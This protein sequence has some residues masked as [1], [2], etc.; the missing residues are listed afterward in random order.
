M[1]AVH[2]DEERMPGPHQERPPVGGRDRI[3]GV[4]ALD[5]HHARAHAA[6]DVDGVDGADPVAIALD[7][8]PPAAGAAVAAARQGEERHDG[9][10][11][12]NAAQ[13]RSVPLSELREHGREG[14]E[15]DP[16]RACP[17]RVRVVEAVRLELSVKGS[18]TGRADGRPLPVGEPQQVDV[19]PEHVDGDPALDVLE[20]QGWEAAAAR[21]VAGRVAAR[22]RSWERVGG[23]EASK[24][25][26]R[27]FP[28]DATS[29]A[30]VW[31]SVSS[32]AARSSPAANGIVALVVPAVFATATEPSGWSR[33]TEPPATDSS[34]SVPKPARRTAQRRSDPS[35][36]LGHASPVDA[37]RKTALRSGCGRAT[38]AHAGHTFHQSKA[39]SE[40]SPATR[41]M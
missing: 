28:P 21:V 19:A 23:R 31:P 30:S 20:A 37:T 33:A 15:R 10:E 25:R 11:D 3:V 26:S 38:P 40:P 32:L 41:P 34:L 17:A 18:P 6:F 5:A 29:A 35:P 8:E 39:R 9:S 36:A 13:V 22:P 14:E 4:R 24:T 27:F 16:A 1:R 2:A 12:E 7:E